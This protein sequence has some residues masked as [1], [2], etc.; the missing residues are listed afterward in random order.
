[1]RPSCR[2]PEWTLPAGRGRVVLDTWRELAEGL[3]PAAARGGVEVRLVVADSR[4]ADSAA[5]WVE[6]VDGA[7]AETGTSVQARPRLPISVEIAPHSHRG[8]AGILKDLTADLPPDARVIVASASQVPDPDCASALREL[9]ER[10]GD[11]GL[12]VAPHGHATDLIAVRRASLDV[13]PDR[14]YCDLKEQALAKIVA[15]DS[16]C[17]VDTLRTH[18]TTHSIRT[19]STYLRTLRLLYAEAAVGAAG[20]SPH[21]DGP[22]DVPHVAAS[23]AGPDVGAFAEDGW[24]S[25]ALVEPGADVSPDARL[26]DAVVLRGARVEPG[27]I[28]ARSLVAS[29]AI[30]P[31]GATV[32]DRLVE[33]VEPQE[34]RGQIVPP[35]PRGS[36]LFGRRSTPL[37]AA[38]RTRKR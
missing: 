25:F 9:I 37:P 32:V 35:A 11:V 29:D 24:S 20:E 28:V 31:R 15:A 1:M 13:V 22:P 26:H 7:R 38:R 17:R 33:A 6:P 34:R 19:L 10:D 8:T 21:R 23:A 27:A 14:G 5:A 12:L 4:T 36:R 18:T 3:L 16:G 2:R 30:V